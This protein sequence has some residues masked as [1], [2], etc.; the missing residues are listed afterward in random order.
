MNRESVDCRKVES[1][2]AVKAPGDFVFIRNA[3]GEIEAIDICI[4]G[5][6]GGS[7]GALPITRGQARPNVVEWEWDGNEDKPSLKPSIW[8]NK[9]APGKE[10]RNEWHGHLRAGRLES[11]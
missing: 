5:N 6:E 2:E 1:S 4:P 8:R 9:P 10:S 3:A 7:A 11:E